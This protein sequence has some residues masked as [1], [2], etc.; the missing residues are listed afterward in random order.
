MNFTIKYIKL[1]LIAC[2]NSQTTKYFIDFCF[3]SERTKPL[4]HKLCKATIV[5]HLNHLILHAS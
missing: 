2:G 3:D 1:R 4:M 5:L